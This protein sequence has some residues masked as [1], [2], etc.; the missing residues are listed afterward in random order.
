V[1]VALNSPQD[2]SFK[3]PSSYVC[4]GSNGVLDFVSGCVLKN[5]LKNIYIFI[6]EVNAEKTKYMLLSRHQNAGENYNINIGDRSFENVA[7]S[8]IWE[9]Q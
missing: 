8:N 6:L 3:V 7:Q 1:R 5:K 2:F 9:R 4:V